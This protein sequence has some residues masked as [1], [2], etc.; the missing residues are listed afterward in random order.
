M[1]TLPRVRAS[2]DHEPVGIRPAMLKGDV[3]MN[4]WVQLL[5]CVVFLVALMRWI[6]DLSKLT[7]R[8]LTISPGGMAWGIVLN[9]VLDAWSF[10]LL[11]RYGT[12]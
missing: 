1:D 12:W 9:F 8:D 7:D 11:I 2:K 4:G 6:V 10:F 5:L 3:I